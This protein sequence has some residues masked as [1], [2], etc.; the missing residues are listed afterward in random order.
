M[1]RLGKFTTPA[2]A[3]RVPVLDLP[4]VGTFARGNVRLGKKIV[5]ALAVTKSDWTGRFFFFFFFLAEE[6]SRRCILRMVFWN[7]NTDLKIDKLGS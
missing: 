4:L 1:F 2:A 7:R 3:L 6:L 5:K